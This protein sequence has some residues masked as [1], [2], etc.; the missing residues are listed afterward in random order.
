MKTETGIRMNRWI[1]YTLGRKANVIR[2]LTLP[3]GLW[4]MVGQP[5]FQDWDW[6]TNFINSMQPETSI[7][8]LIFFIWEPALTVLEKYGGEAK[9]PPFDL[10]WRLGWLVYTGAITALFI[11][12]IFVAAFFV[13]TLF[14][15]LVEV[16]IAGWR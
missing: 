13:A 16:L 4:F 11:G 5:S 2:L 15:W 1:D 3:V 8:V 10:L 12:P 7:F 6:R 9:A 14:F